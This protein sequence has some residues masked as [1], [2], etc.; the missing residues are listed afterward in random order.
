MDNLKII[1][2]S[3]AR[4]GSNRLPGKT[5]AYLAGKK[6]LDWHVS[7]V[8]DSAY[9]TKH[10]IVTSTNPEDDATEAFCND[11]NIAM[12]CGLNDDVLSR[13]LGG[14]DVEVFSR[15]A[16]EKVTTLI[17]RDEER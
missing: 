3:Q 6:V 16:L 7:C 4:M 9:M 12:F 1:G 15:A 17:D 5:L 8:A 2:I 11:N 13:Y 10:I 14:F